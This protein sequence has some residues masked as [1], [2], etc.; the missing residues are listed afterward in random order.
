MP[1]L[2]LNDGGV[3]TYNA[4]LSTATSL[5]FDYT[6]AAGQNTPDLAISA[7]N[8]NGATITNGVGTTV[9]L[10]AAVTNPPGTLVIDMSSISPTATKDFAGRINAKG[11]EYLDAPVSGKVGLWSK[12]DSVSQFEEYVVTAR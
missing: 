4:A 7:V 1:T 3:A 6:V 10:A 11:C 5:V 8:T 12:T 2:T 9:S